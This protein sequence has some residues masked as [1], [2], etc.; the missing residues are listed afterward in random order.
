MPPLETEDLAGVDILAAVGPIHGHG[1]PPEGDRLTVKDLEEFAANAAELAGEIRAPLKIGH[2]AGQRL[3]RASGLADDEHPALGWVENV[4]VQGD[5]LV[6]DLRAVPR[7][8]AALIRAGAFRTRSVEFR[9]AYTSQK[10][11]RQYGRVLTG[12]ALLG[13]QAPAVKTLDDIV[14]LYGDHE[15]D[16]T[17]LRSYNW[18][19]AGAA[20]VDVRLAVIGPDDVVVSVD[21]LARRKSRGGADTGDDMP[22]LKLTEE[23]ARALAERLGLEGDIDETKLL[24]AAEA[25]QKELADANTAAEAAEKAKA[26]AEKAAAETVKLSETDVAKLRADADAGRQAAEKLRLKERDDVIVG[27]IRAGRLAPAKKAEYEKHYDEAPDLTARLLADL[28]VDETL[29]RAYGA[30]NDG[31]SPEDQKKQADRE[32]AGVASMLGIPQETLA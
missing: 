16:D 7:K 15:P 12:L 18:T 13:A 21:E 9:P 20:T 31:L 17:D 14:A 32:Y 3:A 30:D 8:L 19:P 2:S 23:A 5:K 6:A 29:L 26:E 28:P 4:R 27:A 1:S 22:E 10:T 24:D 25:R 11:G